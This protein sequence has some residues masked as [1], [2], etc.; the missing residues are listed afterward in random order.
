MELGAAVSF[1]FRERFFAGQSRPEGPLGCHCVETVGDDQEMRG[2]RQGA[3]LDPVVALAVVA[4]VVELDSPGLAGCELEALHQ[5]RREPRVPPHRGPFGPVQPSL[6][7]EQRRVDRDLAEVVEARGPAQPV[8]VRKGK[9]E[10][11]RKPV[12]GAGDPDRVLVGRGVALVDD[13][14]EGLERVQSLPPYACEARVG[15]VD[16]ERHG[17]QRD[18]VPRVAGREE[19]YRRSQRSLPGSGREVRL[20]CLASRD[21]LEECRAD[22]QVDDRDPR[23]GAEIAEQ[24]DAS[25]VAA[26]REERIAAG[27]RAER[28]RRRLE[29]HGPE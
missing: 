8:D 24:L 21:D 12:D 9:P 7:A 3:A 28:H 14:R 29:G 23:D 17:H 6:L 27:E 13:V 26:G 20:E 4:L 2:Q 11:A 15:D 5:S 18:E 16:D 22:R 25:C 10:R 1:D 19:R